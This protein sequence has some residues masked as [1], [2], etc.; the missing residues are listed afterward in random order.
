MWKEYNKETEKAI[1]EFWKKE[2]VFEKAKKKSKNGKTFYLMDGPPFP[3]GRIHLGTGLNK[4]LKDTAMRVKR[5]Q[6]FEVFDIAGWDCHGLPIELKVEK[7]LGLS[8]K[9]DIGSKITAE[10][11]VKACEEFSTKHIKEMALE[12]EN[13]GVWMDFENAYKTL[14]NEYM[15]SVWWSFKKAADKGLLYKGIYPVQVCPHCE[16]PLSFNEVE[17]EKLTDTSVFVK[18]QLAE[19][20]DTFLIIW[21][22]TPWTLPGNTGVMVHPEFEY[23]E[24]QLSNGEKWILAK[25]LSQKIFDTI[26]TGY[27]A[28]KTFKG[29]ELEGLKYK[30]PLEKNLKIDWSKVENANNRYKVI[31][32][33]RYVNLEDGTGLVHCAPGHGKEDFDAGK[34]AGLPAISPV[35]INGLLT[36]EAG[37]YSGK[38]AKVVDSEII[39]DLKNDNALIYQHS[40]SHEYPICW[41]CDTPLLM[42]S[43]PQW[44]LKTEQLRERAMQLNEE[45]NWVPKWVKERFKNWIE[46]GIADWPVTRDR[47]WG[48]P[49][50][51]WE[52]ASCKSVKVIGS[53]E[54]L[55]K[56]AL[57]KHNFKALDFHRPWIDSVKLKCEK[58]GKEM[59]R[60]PEILDGW[61][62]SGVSSWGAL[63]YP[64]TKGLFE[65]YWPSDLN[66]EG[67]DQIRGWWNSELM[68]GMMA[69]DKKP[70][71]A[72]GMHGFVMDLEKKKMS[73]SRGNV[74]TPAEIIEKQNR[75]MMR[76]YFVQ[77]MHGED[78][79]FDWNVFREIAKTFS[80]LQNVI[81]YAGMYL[82]PG[83]AEIE[84]KDLKKLPEED[85]WIVS[86]TN[87]L[88]KAVLQ[89]FESFNFGKVTQALD[90]F[91]AEDL[92]KTYIKL[93]RDRVGSETQDEL[94]KTLNYCILEVLKLMAPIT[95]HLAEFHYHKIKGNSNV[96]SIHL[97]SI[98]QADDKLIDS[99]L[100]NEMQK[101]KEAV[102]VLL[103]LREESKLKLRWVLREAI[104]Q[105]K[106]GRDFG[107][108]KELLAR[109]VKVKRVIEQKIVPT[110]SFWARKELPT[111]TV[112]LNTKADPELK[113]EWELSEL[114]RR[115]QEARKQAKLLPGQKAEL[116]IECS[117]QKFLQKFKSKIE[118]ET[119]TKIIPGAPKAQKE[120]LVEREFALELKPGR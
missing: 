50:P 89:N 84:E 36:E 120:K 99:E 94:E 77:L 59:K 49:A 35:K 42:I 55:K 14:D 52:C 90:Y 53:S 26:E 33:A 64:Q 16:T 39:E 95:P 21:T 57:G 119:S 22:T 105:T 12:F 1:Q 76:Y 40:Y 114:L 48:T 29:K 72:I 81:N 83:I 34:K 113:E 109:M 43:I 51:I 107:K 106:S 96:E 79:A 63:K 78:F 103:A 88:K 118:E 54:E 23:I 115:I 69:F 18:F 110:E 98:E 10:K 46:E 71:K 5:M 97:H 102:E 17:H 101:T 62:D 73:K 9:A 25:E 45:V 93:V 56:R 31:L 58:C 66:I 19:K 104:L 108:T 11:F 4:S 28:L 32:S 65:K 61:F 116:L 86:K 15:E 3:S 2:K 20:K 44:F 47:Y 37:K 82:K 117:D 75:D 85:K 111:T 68:C 80:T 41:R 60:V 8:G 70:F 91:I 6:G 24:A 112:F 7:E 38:K 87:S 92:S 13:L 67:R 27:T 74:V 30:N 100:E